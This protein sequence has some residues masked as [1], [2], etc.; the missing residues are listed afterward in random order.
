M[1]GVSLTY[2]YITNLQGD[3]LYLIDASKNVVVS[4]DYDPYGKIIGTHDYSTQAFALKPTEPEDTTKT[5]ADLNPLRYRGYY[6]DNDD[7][8]FYYLQSRYYDATTCRFISADEYTDTDT[9]YLGYNMFAYCNNNPINYADHEGRFFDWIGGAIGA[10]VG[11]LTGALTT[12]ATG[13]SWKDILWSG[14]EGAVCGFFAPISSAWSIG[15]RAYSAFSTALSCW[16]SGASFWTGLGCGLLDFGVST[17]MGKMPKFGYAVGTAI[18]LT[19]GLGASMCVTAITTGIENNAQFAREERRK[20]HPQP[21][22]AD[23]GERPF[24]APDPDAAVGGGGGRRVR[25]YW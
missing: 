12:A 3:V 22:L 23:W 8:G 9:G 1:Q 17:F 24:I 6:Y 20:S 2:Y 25:C 19:F 5:L 18:D 11:G 4:Y 7:V 21:N 13:G 14:I 10:V 15:I 16:E